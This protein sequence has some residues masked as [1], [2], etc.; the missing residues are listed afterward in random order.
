[1]CVTISLFVFVEL[2]IFVLGSTLNLM[3]KQVGLYTNFS[4]RKHSFYLSLINFS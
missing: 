1:M 4:R 3:E 2:K